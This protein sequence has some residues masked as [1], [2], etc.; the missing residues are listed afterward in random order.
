MTP[1]STIHT[2][3][4]LTRMS[5]AEGE[6]IPILLT[7]VVVGDGGGNEV[8]PDVGMTQL[9]RERY[10]APIGRLYRDEGMPNHFT[11]EVSIPASVG[12]FTL[13]EIGVLDA[14]GGL[15]VV[16]N[17]PTTY[18]PTPADGAYSDTVLRISFMTSNADVVSIVVDPN[19][20][21]VTQ[22]WISNNVTACTIIPGG[23]A[24]QVLAKRSNACGD[25]EWIDPDAVN[26]SVDMIEET[27]TLAAGQTVV[28]WALV[29]NTGLAV[30]V[31]RQRL[32]AEEWTADALI[33]TR[34]TLAS[35]YP[36]GTKIV[37]V[38]NEPAGTM[39]EP[40]ERPKN[41][42]DVPD[43]ALARQNLG[44]LSAIETRKLMPPGAVLMHLGL[45]PPEGFLVANGAA[46]SRSVYADLF[47]VYGT[48]FGA[49][50]GVSTFN[51]PDLR[52]EF[53]RFADAGRGVDVNRV[54]GTKQTQ[55]VQAHKHISAMGEAY[56]S[57]MFG[58]GTVRGNYGSNGGADWDNYLYFTSDG[59]P[60]ER[61]NPNAPGVIG[62]ETR[63]R[64]IAVL[65]CIKY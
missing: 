37:G 5:Q 2:A 60:H 25:T 15:F 47:A 22:E 13:R 6:N 44:V 1:Y 29:S 61:G 64:N 10:R 40:L 59:M 24:G 17:L 3:H 12:G 23:N 31:N 56:D 33:N 30:Y 49:G 4:G 20:T 9:V 51:L 39:P 21:V 27:Q 19:V 16:G 34:I 62:S 63:P 50:N 26:I 58:R 55:Q 54:I 18:K 46:V 57:N 38:Q 7:D 41:L 53:P 42:A 11:V 45:T 32:L 65:G 52:A 35:S 48:R 36:A 14:D 28:D 8:T 43:K